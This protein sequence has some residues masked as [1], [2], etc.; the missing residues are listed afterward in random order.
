MAKSH[1]IFQFILL[2][3]CRWWA[4]LF[5]FALLCFACAKRDQTPPPLR[6]DGKPA[7]V[8][9]FT[10]VEIS[11][12]RDAL[13][14]MTFPLPVGSTAKLLPRPLKPV[15]LEYVDFCRDLE[16]KGRDGGN[17]VEYW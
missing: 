17:T 6:T 3:R 7:D 13:A 9:H 14:Q 4:S 8:G 15:H 10:A 2:W 1:Q 11:R 5:A 16:H 12:I